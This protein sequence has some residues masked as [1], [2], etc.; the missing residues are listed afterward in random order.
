[1]KKIRL[2]WIVTGL[3]PRTAPAA[4][5]LVLWQMPADPDTGTYYFTL[6]H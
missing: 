1:V 5:G 3:P 6:E 2:V 4:R